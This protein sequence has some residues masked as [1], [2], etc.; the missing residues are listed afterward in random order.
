MGSWQERMNQRELEIKRLA[1]KPVESPTLSYG[2]RMK[3]EGDEAMRKLKPEEIRTLELLDKLDV[4]KML[5][6]IRDEVWG[7]HGTIKTHEFTGEDFIY[8]KIELSFKYEDPKPCWTYV[9]D[10]KLGFYK[11]VIEEGYQVASSG[12]DGPTYLGAWVPA[13]VARRFG[14][15]KIDSGYG[16][17]ESCGFDERIGGDLDVGIERD[18]S[19]FCLEVVHNKFKLNPQ[20]LDE[21]GAKKFIE[22]ILLD[23]CIYEKENKNLPTD[24]FER[25]EHNK[26]IIKQAVEEK[27]RF[28]FDE[29]GEKIIELSGLVKVY[30]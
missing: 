7:G 20:L 18:H 27:R 5:E 11:E 22:K 2:E 13:R 30:R 26:T 8:R 29:R 10:T 25:V 3:I 24:I 12:F 16:V 19:G 28:S 1:Q 9:Y 21:T 6:G 17:V 4:R 15:H 23:N 14:H